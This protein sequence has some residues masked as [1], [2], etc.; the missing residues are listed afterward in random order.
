MR[1]YFTITNIP[2][3]TQEIRESKKNYKNG[4]SHMIL[5]DF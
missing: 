2:C 4:I 1:I 5:K 3:E